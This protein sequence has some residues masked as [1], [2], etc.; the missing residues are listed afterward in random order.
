MTDDERHILRGLV[1]SLATAVYNGDPLDEEAVMSLLR[2][3]IRPTTLTDEHVAKALD[4]LMASLHG[5]LLISIPFAG[6][7]TGNTPNGIRAAIRRG[8]LDVLQVDD[9]TR[10][11][12]WASVAGYFGISPALRDQ[13]EISWRT[14]AGCPEG[15]LFMTGPAQNPSA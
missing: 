11:V 9:K 6:I 3:D 15:P 13:M 10:G 2:M 12:T 7:L 14:A 4:Q 8:K 1:M 5:E